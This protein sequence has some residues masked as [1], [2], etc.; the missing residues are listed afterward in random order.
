MEC[1]QRSWS[2]HSIATA[3]PLR[4]AQNAEPLRCH[5][6]GFVH[7]NVRAVARRSRRPQGALLRCHGVVTALSLR[8]MQSHCVHL[9]VLTNFATQWERRP[10][11]TGV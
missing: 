5:C 6:A 1:P 8:C 3:F 2:P 4:A 7:H 10:S 9:G 11:V